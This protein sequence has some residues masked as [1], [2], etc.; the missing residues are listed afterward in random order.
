MSPGDA[1]WDN[2]MAPTSYKWSFISIYLYN[3]YITPANGLINLNG[4]LFFCT[5]IS[6]VMG[7]LLITSRGLL[8]LIMLGGVVM[9]EWG[10]NRGPSLHL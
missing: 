7:P 9:A 1:R 3:I 4:Q 10:R 6:G 5:Y 2:I 8:Q